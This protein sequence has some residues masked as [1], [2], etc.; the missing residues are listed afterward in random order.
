MKKNLIMRTFIFC[1]FIFSLT[2]LVACQMTPE[3]LKKEKLQKIL[4]G[5]N[6]D[7]K[8]FND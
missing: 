7:I 8:N 3:E 5:W 6:K 2:T 4:K 1:I